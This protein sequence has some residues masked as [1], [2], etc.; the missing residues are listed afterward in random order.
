MTTEKWNSASVK[1]KNERSDRGRKK[2]VVSTAYI[3]TEPEAI[4][5]GRSLAYKANNCG[6]STDP[7][8]IPQVTLNTN[9]GT[10]N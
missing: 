4:T 1:Q 2:M 5:L 8:G 9:G 10:E 3:K 7:W 6:P